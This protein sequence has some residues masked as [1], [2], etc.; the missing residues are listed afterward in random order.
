MGRKTKGLGGET[1][2]CRINRVFSRGGGGGGVDVKNDIIF[3][4]LFSTV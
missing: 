1:R 3:L 4:D 2:G